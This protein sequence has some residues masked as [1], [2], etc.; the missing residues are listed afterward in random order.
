[1]GDARIHAYIDWECS[2]T[3]DAV[4]VVRQLAEE[5]MFTVSGRETWARALLT[6]A[7]HQLR[8][9]EPMD[10]TVERIERFLSILSTRDLRRRV[11]CQLRQLVHDQREQSA[12]RGTVVSV[13]N[14]AGLPHV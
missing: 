9:A 8:N 2:R 6:S 10:A 1:M 14:N 5:A 3:S 4:E 11:C 7:R 12:Q 13:P